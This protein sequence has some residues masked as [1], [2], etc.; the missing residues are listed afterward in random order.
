M[1]DVV[2]DFVDADHDDVDHDD[3]G[4]VEEGVGDGDYHEVM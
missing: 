4:H 3:V 2:D 1:I